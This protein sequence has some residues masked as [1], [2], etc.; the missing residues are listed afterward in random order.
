MSPLWFL[1]VLAT[2]PCHV[3]ATLR[4]LPIPGDGATAS[5]SQGS[6]AA[7]GDGAP[8]M[9]I[10]WPFC[11]DGTTPVSSSQSSVAL[12][13]VDVPSLDI[14][15]PQSSTVTTNSPTIASTVVLPSSLGAR[16]PGS[17]PRGV[18]ANGDGAS[19]DDISHTVPA[20][21]DGVPAVDTFQVVSAVASTRV[22]DVANDTLGTAPLWSVTRRLSRDGGHSEVAPLAAPVTRSSYSFPILQLNY[23]PKAT[24]IPSTPIHSNHDH[25]VPVS[26]RSVF[27]RL[28]GQFSSIAMLAFFL[29]ALAI[30]HMWQPGAGAQ[31]SRLPPRWEPA[32][33]VSFRSWTQ[34]LMLWTISSDLQPQQQ[35]AL[36]ISQLGG[37]ARDVARTMTPNEVYAGGIVNG[38]Q[39]DPITYLLHGLAQRFAPSDDEFCL[40]A[41]QDLLVFPV[42]AMKASMLLLADLRSCVKELGLKEVEPCPLRQHP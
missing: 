31:S 1:F 26:P 37:A 42:V 17:K 36:I 32:S 30:C 18:F 19:A 34:D 12:A 35:C 15:Q 22:T 8:T 27:D 9:G 24:S 13:D 39:V 7:A 41:T 2:V 29:P 14:R 5:T 16:A 4:Y 23:Y 40:R 25:A 11:G 28:G 10:S 3:F 20:L 6:F 33:N 21:G 38:Q